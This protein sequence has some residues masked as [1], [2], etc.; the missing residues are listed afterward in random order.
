M[1]LK[2][3]I[4]GIGDASGIPVILNLAVRGT[5]F[6]AGPVHKKYGVLLLSG[7]VDVS[8]RRK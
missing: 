8:G 3:P 2:R 5:H 7:K 4:A 1:R 6:W